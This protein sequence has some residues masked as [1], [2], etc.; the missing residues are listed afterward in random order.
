MISRRPNRRS[1][2]KS[3]TRLRFRQPQPQ[4]Q[5]QPSPFRP[6]PAVP[7]RTTGRGRVESA[8]IPSSGPHSHHRRLSMER[9]RPPGMTT[10]PSPS[11]STIRPTTTN[12]SRASAAARELPSIGRTKSRTI[13]SAPAWW[14][15]S[16][17]SASPASSSSPSRYCFSIV[18]TAVRTTRR[19][20]CQRPRRQ[21]GLSF[22]SGR[23][24]PRRRPLR[25]RALRRAL[26]PAR[27]SVRLP[28]GRQHRRRRRTRPARQIRRAR[29]P[30]PPP[31]ISAPRR[32]PRLPISAPPLLPWCHPRQ[33][34]RRPPP[35]LVPPTATPLPA[36]PFGRAE[37]DSNGNCSLD[38][39]GNIRVIC[40]PDGWFIDGPIGGRYNNSAG[41]REVTVTRISE[42]STA[43]G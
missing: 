30:P 28:Q 34:P 5:R 1:L 11:T 23:R 31:L 33:L 22:L 36:H 7:C 3:G 27:A 29:P 42:A 17:S 13:H 19:R 8:A 24:R 6:P 21:A 25:A 43:C 41:W 35:R 38:G 37:C 12:P 39:T 20:C 18:T 26:R 9:L 2:P 32:Q 16:P 10:T 40:A 15:F 14:C 4:P